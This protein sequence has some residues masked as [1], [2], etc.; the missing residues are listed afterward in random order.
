MISKHLCTIDYHDLRFKSSMNVYFVDFVGEEMVYPVGLLRSSDNNAVKEVKEV[1][2]VR[3]K[4]GFGIRKKEPTADS[5][6]PT[7]REKQD[8]KSGGEY[9]P[10][11]LILSLGGARKIKETGYHRPQGKKIP[12]HPP[13]SKGCIDR[14]HR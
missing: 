11:P 2:E 9:S 13:F 6:Q 3:A 12:L 4:K 1:E 10:S 5:R 14:T 8:G 7:V